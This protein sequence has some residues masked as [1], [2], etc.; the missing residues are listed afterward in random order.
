[1]QEAGGSSPSPPTTVTGFPSV[2][3]FLTVKWYNA[4]GYPK[5]SREGGAQDIRRSS[6]RVTHR[7]TY[8]AWLLVVFFLVLAAGCRSRGVDRAR[9]DSPASLSSVRPGPG[10]LQQRVPQFLQLVSSHV[11]H[12]QH[13]PVYPDVAHCFQVLLSGGLGYLHQ[14]VLVYSSADGTN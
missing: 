11:G 10:H 12:V 5:R 3:C 8:L 4:A 6:Q 2:Y 14:D 1:M 7:E 13:Q 9:Q